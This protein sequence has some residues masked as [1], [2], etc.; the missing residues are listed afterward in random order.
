[1]VGGE[2]G[3]LVM[4]KVELERQHHAHG[5]T[6]L[7]LMIV[8]V[9]VGI[10]ATQVISGWNSPEP[11]LKSAA[12][13]LRTDFNLARGEAAKRNEDVLVDFFIKGASMQ[14]A[15]LP[16]VP[17]T[18]SNDG[19]R[20]C[21]DTNSDDECLKKDDDFVKEV[22]FRDEIRFYSQ[23]LVAVPPPQGPN[24]KA[25]GGAW[26]GDP[27]SFASDR[28]VMQPDG[29]STLSGT[30]YLYA[31]SPDSLAVVESGPFAVVVS[32]TGRVRLVRWRADAWYRK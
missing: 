30:V 13:N 7:E 12:F 5:F 21:I 25:G 4:D 3:S 23:T 15:V 22:L 29:T 9:I 24:V 1:M 18:M 2:G 14:D 17:V 28:V 19:Y 31:P 10:L 27:V 16:A 26:D 11:K 20:I 6:L 8:L 32:N